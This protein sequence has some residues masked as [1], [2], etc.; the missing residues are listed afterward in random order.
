MLA[1]KYYLKRAKIT[2]SIMAFQAGLGNMYERVR[3]WRPIQLVFQ[4]NTQNFDFDFETIQLQKIHANFASK[5]AILNVL[6]MGMGFCICVWILSKADVLQFN[7]ILK[8]IMNFS[9]EIIN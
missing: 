6:S 7:T 9:F 2:H 8:Q 3:Y 5:H 1:V 4:N